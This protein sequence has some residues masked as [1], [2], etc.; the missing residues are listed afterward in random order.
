MPRRKPRR[1]LLDNLDKYLAPE[2]KPAAATDDQWKQARQTLEL[3]AHT[4]LGTIA[5]AKKT[6]DGDATAEKEFK[7]VL[8]L[9]PGYAS[10]AYTLGTLILRER[11]VERIPEALFYIARA[12]EI[13]GPQALTAQGKTAAETYLKKAYAGYHG[14]ETGLDDRQES[15]P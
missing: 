6:P 2:N 4:V 15:W 7:K 3:Q 14:D 12:I 9:S 1:I 10:I 5:M 13:T 8:E 11:K